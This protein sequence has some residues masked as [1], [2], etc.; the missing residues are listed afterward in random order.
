M[1]HIILDR[2][3]RMHGLQNL[4]DGR[5]L[6]RILQDKLGVVLGSKSHAD[7]TPRQKKSQQHHARL[8]SQC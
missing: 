2:H 6:R 8:D 1:R 4:G 5:G 3:N 7:I